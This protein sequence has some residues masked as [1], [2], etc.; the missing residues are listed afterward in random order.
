MDKPRSVIRVAYKP[1]SLVREQSYYRSTHSFISW[2]A[3]V[4]TSLS[5][6][7]ATKQLS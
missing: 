7:E 3:H 4:P 1:E 5:P 6:T 2:T